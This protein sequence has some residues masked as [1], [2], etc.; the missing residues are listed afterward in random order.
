MILHILSHIFPQ[1]IPCMLTKILW[2]RIHVL[3]NKTHKFHNRQNKSC[4]G[5]SIL[6]K[7]WEPAT[8]NEIADLHIYQIW[9]KIMTPK[10]LLD[11]YYT[12]CSLEF[13]NWQ[14][15]NLPCELV[16]IYKVKALLGKSTI[17]LPPQKMTQ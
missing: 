2:Q 13:P 15:A 10:T 5:E 12:R 11:R 1:K 9:K 7:Q 17:L 6:V 3:E 8:V 14:C 4:L 16:H